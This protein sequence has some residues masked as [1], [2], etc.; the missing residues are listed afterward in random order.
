MLTIFIGVSQ[1]LN[2]MRLGRHNHLFLNELLFSVILEP[3]PRIPATDLGL[4]RPQNAWNP[5]A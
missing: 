4:S 3:A 1:Q 5:F 2:P